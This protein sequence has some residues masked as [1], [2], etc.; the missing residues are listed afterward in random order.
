MHKCILYKN[1]LYNQNNAD[2][3]DE[4]SQ[5]TIDT[6]LSNAT[7][8]DKGISETSNKIDFSTSKSNEDYTDYNE[9]GGDD[10][11]T[12][13]GTNIVPIVAVIDTN[14]PSTV[15]QVHFTNI[16]GN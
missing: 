16:T 9:E 3:F 8:L 2:D 1:I 12:L 7:Y 14:T 13:E 4:E 5:A 10:N 6:Q 11:E 15:D